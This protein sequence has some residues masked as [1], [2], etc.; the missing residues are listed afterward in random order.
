M[1]ED[2][3]V[4]VVRIR[5][6]RAAELPAMIRLI[7]DCV[8]CREEAAE[9]ARGRRRSF[10]EPPPRPGRAARRV[11]LELYG[12]LKTVGGDT[13]TNDL[14]ELAGCANVAADAKGNVLFSAERLVQADP[15]VI[16]VVGRRPRTPDRWHAVPGMPTC[17]PSA[18]AGCSLWTATGS[19]P[20]RRCPNPWRG[21]VKPLP[22]TRQTPEGLY[23]PFFKITYNEKYR[24]ATLHNSGC[25]FHCGVCS[26]RLHS[27]ADGVPGQVYPR[28]RAVSRRGSH[29]NRRC[30]R[31]PWTNCSSWAASRP[32]PR[33]FRRCSTSAR[34]RWA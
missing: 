31:W 25:T 34:T 3:A 33:N 19:S 27:G 30:G 29:E 23:M 14:L 8:D 6:G 18:R 17:E 9:L 2:L 1:L 13:Y 28:P 16:L 7:G 20:A 21:F 11:F 5:S 22:D 24:F 15:D 12:P 32:W 26:Y 10:P 4:P